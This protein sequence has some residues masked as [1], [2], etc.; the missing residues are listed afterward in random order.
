[1]K[2][3]FKKLLDIPIPYVITVV[4]V[5]SILVVL[6]IQ[7]SIG[8]LQLVGVAAIGILLGL[9]LYLG[10]VVIKSLISGFIVVYV[11][12]LYTYLV[13]NFQSY[14]I[15]PFLLT[16]SAVF[17]FLGQTYSE[18]SHYY[19]LR[20]RSLWG[21]VLAITLVAVKSTI[22]VSG[23]GFW[24][25]EVIGLNYL[26]IYIML[27]RVWLKKSKKTRLNKPNIV[28]EKTEDTFKFIYIENKLDVQDNKWTT[29]K[30]SKEQ[31]AYPYVYNEVIKAH[32]DGKIL[33]IVSTLT[34][35]KIYDVG[36]VTINKAKKIP[37]LY[38]EAKKDTYQEDILTSFIN[39]ITQS[40]EQYD[41]AG[42]NRE[43]K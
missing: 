9:Q 41:K 3:F 40:K 32:E 39:D 34:T 6:K 5:V 21:S 23:L 43:S 7:G 33:V 36:E 28:K 42:G 19:S 1:M 15:Q 14:T 16:L 18:Q 11:T 22:I 30:P 25:A 29:G 4:S 2:K 26:V 38:M 10:S 17:V 8:T 35:S 24:I 31:N 37:Y 13:I 27:W 12:S 20:S